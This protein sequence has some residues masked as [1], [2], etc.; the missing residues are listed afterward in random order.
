MTMLRIHLLRIWLLTPL[1]TL[2]LWGADDR[3]QLHPLPPMA[4]N[5]KSG[6]SVGSSIP[7]FEAIDTQGKRQTFQSLRGPKGLVLSFSRS[8][9]WCPFCKAQLVDLNSKLDDFKKQGLA[10]ASVTYDS[11][12]VLRHFSE[13]Q[14]I[15]F[16]MLSDPD[17]KM[18]KA[19]GIFNDNVE[20]GNFAY[21]IPFPVTYIINARGIVT[22]KYFE[23]DYRERYSAASILSREFG[24]GGVE[25]TTVETQHLK[26]SY[27]SSDAVLAPGRRITL[28]VDVDL[29]SKMHVYAP[30][31]KGYIPIDWQMAETKTSLALPASYPASHMLNLPAI[32]ETVPVYSSRLRMVRDIV[33][34]QEA[35]IAP[36]LGPDRTM[37][38]EGSFRYQAC[39]DRECYLPKTI[40]LKWT[41]KVSK[42][43]TQRVPAEIQRKAN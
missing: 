35:E 27:S 33:I 8:A 36:V 17:S 32:K 18:I 6:P 38:I 10:V 22:T 9:D 3:P 12:E 43:D 29:A 40:P 21:G 7:T 20:P 19:F 14:G 31:I 13:R 23:N 1:L 37:T 24:A 2:P 28:V 4:K 34:G 26:L 41:F 5:A 15:K 25:K 42:L 16:N 11:V 39:D 30:G